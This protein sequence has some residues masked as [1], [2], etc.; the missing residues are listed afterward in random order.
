VVRTGIIGSTVTSVGLATVSSGTW[1]NTGEFS[2]G[3]NGTGTLTMT[4]GRLTNTNGYIGRFAGSVGT[5]TVSSGTWANSGDLFVGPSGTGTLTM[6]GGLVSVG[7]TL[8]QG[9]SGAINL[10]SGG[11]LQ[12][13]TGTTGGVLGV[14][15]L[16]NNGTLV[17]N[18]SD[19]STYSGIISGTGAVT[20]QGAGTLT[21][22]GAN[23]YSGL[24]TITSGALQVGNSGTTGS[25]AGNVVNNSSLIFNRSDASTYSGIISGT[26]AVTKLGVGTFTLDGANTYIG[27]TS[28]SSGTFL[29]NGDQ[30]A[31]TGAVDITGTGILGGIGTIGGSTTIGSGATL[32]PGQS[33]GVL[34]FG[35]GANLAFTS[36]NSKL[37]M[38]I[39]GTVRGTSYDGITLS[40]SGTL[41]YGGDAT[42]TI[43]TGLADGTV[44]DLFAFT[45]PDFGT[46]DSITLSSGGGYSGGSFNSLIAGT[47]ILIDSNGQTLTFI[48]ST[49]DLSVI[50]EPTS[51]ALFGLGAM[52]VWWRVRRRGKLMESVL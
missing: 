31:A 6:S 28:S 43:T 34:T 52:A 33:P 46:F 16:T 19:A 10:N 14:S 5:A 12:I 38:E 39:S 23:S 25:I 44:L 13:G 37:L 51:L 1:D 7:G 3:Y 24:T 4:G 42:F 47:W 11:T 36:T 27:G 15:T 40:N 18:R 49:G 48:E 32:S 45:G 30:T 21:L 35:P 26:G 17:F 2:A 50:P 8:T 22:D 41:T 9:A 20:K 29:I